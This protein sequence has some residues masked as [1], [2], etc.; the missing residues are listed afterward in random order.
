VVLAVT[1]STAAV[2]I[3]ETKLWSTVESR[4]ILGFKADDA[5]VQATMPEG[6]KAITLPKGP[7]AGVNLL[8]VFMDRHL[9]LDP[10]GKPQDPS[11]NPIAAFMS[12]GVSKDVEGVRAYITRIYE[13]SPVVDPYGNSVAAVITRDGQKTVDAGNSVERTEIW[14]VKP[15]GGGSIDFKLTYDSAGLNWV[16]GG[17]SRPYSSAM[18]EYSHIYRYDQA[19]ELVM[20][21]TS[22]YELSNEWEFSSSVPEFADM[23]NGSEELIAIL[24]IPVYVRDVFEP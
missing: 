2:A 10:E 14:S 20:N 7:L 4:I 16:A 19:A 13:T 17:V 6:W 23:F 15:E 8:V 3:A 9:I 5:A 24:N 1:F 12:Y 21:N 18:P 22:G 11:S